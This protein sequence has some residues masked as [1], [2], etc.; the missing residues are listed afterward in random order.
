MS[1]TAALAD[2]DGRTAKN[3]WVHRVLG[4]EISPAATASGAQPDH[5]IVGI[6]WKAKDLINDQLDALRHAILAT[7]HPL[8]ARA[9]EN[10]LGGFSGGV[11]VRFQTS[12][13]ACR[14]SAPD[15]AGP[16]WQDVRKSAAALT[17]AIAA[18]PL[19]SVIEKNPFNIRVTI[20][21]DVTAAVAAI[22]L[23]AKA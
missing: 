3:E 23:H 9:C 19:L 18:N 8:A 6:W 2:Q 1:E 12:L 22:L 16:A 4:L 10:G 5:D 13:I 20:H 15:A 21:E 11:L 17:D 7:E 14:N